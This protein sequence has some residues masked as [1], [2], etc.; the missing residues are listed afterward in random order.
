MPNRAPQSAWVEPAPTRAAKLSR[1]AIVRA[2]IEIADS[3][4]LGA[5]SIRNVAGVLGVRPMSLYTHIAS[6][7]QL[8]DLM[9]DEVVAELLVPEPLPEQ[10]REA[11]AE[12]A[13]R[14]HATL[15]AHSWILAGFGRPNEL[16]PNALRHAEQSSRA[17]AGLRLTADEARTVLW[18]VDDFT[19]GHAMR[20]AALKQRIVRVPEVDAAEHPTLAK[21]GAA[22]AFERPTEET[23]EVGL[24]ILLDGIERRFS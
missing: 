21:L 22:A 10:W 15:L 12:I 16:G 20:V 13:R 24:A 9:T 14:T 17:L 18:I 23:F 6:K 4:A 3:E 1:A 11:L 19:A 7:D 5:V 8:L 2:A